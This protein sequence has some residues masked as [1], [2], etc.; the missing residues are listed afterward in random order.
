MKDE[1]NKKSGRG[2]WRGGVKPRKNRIYRTI[3]LDADCVEILK[4]QRN[5]TD[6]LNDAIRY[7]DASA[8][9][10]DFVNK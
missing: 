3:G 7:Y 4:R 8:A 5:Q 6:F 2:G 1:L 9:G 10:G